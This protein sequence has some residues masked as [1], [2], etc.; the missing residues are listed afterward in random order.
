MDKFSDSPVLNKIQKTKK[1]PAKSNS[2]SQGKNKKGAKAQ[3]KSAPKEKKPKSQPK[4][5]KAKT[6]KR[7]ASKD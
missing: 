5:K 7:P 1:A 4:E 2:R 6:V 3:T